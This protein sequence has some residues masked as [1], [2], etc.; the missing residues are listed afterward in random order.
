ME[1]NEKAAP[2]VLKGAFV[3]RDPSTAMP[4]SRSKL[5]QSFAE[6]LLAERLRR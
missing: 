3:D 6:G 2:A 5:P 4:G 1:D